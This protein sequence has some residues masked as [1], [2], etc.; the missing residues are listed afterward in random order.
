MEEQD[1]LYLE[2]G[3]ILKNHY[4][5][6]KILGERSN[7]SIVYIGENLKTNEKIVIKEFFPKNLA[8]RDMDK[9]SI[10]CKSSNSKDRYEKGLNNFLLEGKIMEEIKSNASAEYI[11]SF[12]ENGTAYVVMKYHK[13]DDLEK[14]IK[15][16]NI[17]D[18]QSFVQKIVNPL[19]DTVN[20]LHCLGYL[21]RDIKPSNIIVEEEK[22][23][24][25]DFGST[26]NYKTE[27]E[28]NIMVTPGFSPIEFYSEKSKQ[29]RA[30]DIYSIAA[31]LYYYFSGIIPP[32]ATN[33]IIDDE[34]IKLSELNKEI[35]KYLEKLILK[36]LSMNIKDRDKT[37]G[38]FKTNLKIAVHMDKLGLKPVW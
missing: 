38:R 17:K 24:L 10:L 2:C 31:M 14:H 7:F 22:P 25:I 32:D 19:L 3:L 4:L 35:P 18:W 37:I 9:K 36:N 28:K 30:S 13:G 5:I 27:G 6:E 12:T 20:N 29:E 21:H 11:D 23:I 8:L 34:I 16:G 26:I 33:R 15:S 1:Y